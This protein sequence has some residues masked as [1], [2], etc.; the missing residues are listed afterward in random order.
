[1]QG[2]KE[3]RDATY[4]AQLDMRMSRERA[5]LQ[6][7]A[8][9]TTK[10]RAEP[11]RAYEVALRES[12]RAVAALRVYEVAATTIP[13]VTSYCALLGRENVEGIKHLEMEDDRI[14]R[15]SD[16]TVGKPI[17]HWHLSDHDVRDYTKSLG[18]AEVS[19][20]LALN[21]RT[22][23]QETFLDALLLY[24]RSTREKEGSGMLASRLWL[25]TPRPPGRT[26][27]GPNN[28][29][30]HRRRRNILWVRIEIT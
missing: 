3:D 13:E 21:R 27:R 7:L 5:D 4:A 10:V 11:N 18:F 14:R 2:A 28:Q 20:L 30:G 1:V 6:G 8:I 12:E 9:A 29:T 24:S 15:T 23:F 16:Q 19:K 26:S 17:L 22:K 25:P